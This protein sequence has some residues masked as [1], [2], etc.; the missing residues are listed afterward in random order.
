MNDLTKKPEQIDIPSG[1]SREAIG[2]IENSWVVKALKQ[3]IGSIFVSVATGSGTPEQKAR[4]FMELTSDK[5]SGFRK[6]LE[7]NPKIPDG[8]VDDAIFYIIAQGVADKLHGATA[9]T[10]AREKPVV[11]ENNK[12]TALIKQTN[13][14]PVEAGLVKL[15]RNFHPA[16]GGGMSIGF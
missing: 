9:G 3:N 7:K 5:I 2:S 8:R 1:L 10:P 15:F 6:D 12:K 16:A 11:L 4:E 13:I 14:S